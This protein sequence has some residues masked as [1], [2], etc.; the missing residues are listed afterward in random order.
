MADKYYFSTRDLLYIA[1]LACLGGVASTYVGY[2]GSAFGS[3]TGIPYS[4]QLLSGLHIFWIVLIV[5]IVDKKGSGALAG[6]F[7]GFVE[8]VSGS[9]LGVG[10]VLVSLVEGAFAEAGFWPLKR[11][12]RILAYVV[13]GALG[14]WS[15]ILVNQLLYSR[16]G[17]NLYLIGTV[18]AFSLLSG[19]IFAGL[20][21]YGIYRGLVDSGIA[22]QPREAKRQG[23]ASLPVA[24][25]VVIVA[26]VAVLAGAYCL[27]APSGAVTATPSPAAGAANSTHAV[28]Y[29]TCSGGENNTY[30]LADYSGRFVTVSAAKETKAGTQPAMDYTGLPLRAI[31][32]E[33][34]AGGSPRYVDVVASDG[35]RQTFSV[36]EVLAGDDVI[37]VPNA[38]GL[39]DVVA[40]GMPGSAWVRDVIGM[41]LY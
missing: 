36:S 12:S 39:C 10:V 11:H 19:A 41:K 13:S 30:D 2:L 26:F 17:G 33:Q 32:E 25:A 22:R 35:Y 24:I 16:F 1:I 40:K 4:G 15:N 20:L 27:D 34:C 31:V 14:S 3:L 37:L 18:S 38:N 5:A 8:F 29:A 21:G 28:F 23:M 7:K 9:H 6:L